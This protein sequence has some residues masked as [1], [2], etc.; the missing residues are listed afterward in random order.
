VKRR[1]SGLRGTD[2][3]FKCP[4]WVLVSFLAAATPSLAQTPNATGS[5][6]A[7]RTEG[8]LMLIE[9]GRQALLAD[10]YVEASEALEAAMELSVFEHLAP[11]VQHQAFLIASFAASGRDDYLGAH[12]FMMAATEYDEANAA[13]W[14]LRARYASWVEEWADA[15]LSITTVARRWSAEIAKDEHRELISH[16]GHKLRRDEHRQREYLELL[17][18]LFDARFTA[19]FGI[20][21]DA[22]WQD[23]VLDALANGDMKRAR[24]FAA[25]IENTDTLLRMRIDKR[26]DAI[27]RADA[28]RFDLAAAAKRRS[29][30]LARLVTDEP[31]SLQAFVQYGYALL[32][33]GRYAEL[34]ARSEVILRRID[35]APAKAPPYD[36]LDD[37]LNWLYNHKAESL[38]ALGRW[39]EALAV[40]E[41]GRAKRERGSDNV[42]QAI[43]LGFHYNDA[44]QPQKALDVLANVD[45]ARALSPYGRMQLQHVRYRAYLQL[46]NR[47]EADNVLAY[48]R[49]HQDDADDTWLQVL[50][51]SGDVERAAAQLIAQ[52]KD[53]EKRSSAL[54]AV[55]DYQRPPGLPR[56]QES[57]RRWHTLLARNDVSAAIDEVGRRERQPVFRAPD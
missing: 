39:D 17:R 48:L 21:P 53:A 52:L 3:G 18:A 44:G 22:F 35:Q 13:Q 42:S 9:S 26:F 51:D 24:V 41:A 6:L 5:D 36:D 47:A 56:M 57:R 30:S 45:W 14:L 4:I 37:S 40:M 55:Q 10:K 2:V 19:Q 25:R 29:R 1:I 12:E 28:K 46:E 32:D 8:A 15:A 20:Q 27:V 7:A 38:R 49:E 34:L 33:E 16:I 54:A 31:R 23:L 11:G 50:L 43:N